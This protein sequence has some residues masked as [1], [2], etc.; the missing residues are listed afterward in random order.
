MK[1]DI[2][3]FTPYENKRKE[4]KDL[5]KY[6]YGITV[7]TIF[8]IGVSFGVNHFRIYRLEKDIEYYTNKMTDSI[9][10][11]ELKEAENINSQINILTEYDKGIEDI[12]KAVRNRDL[13]SDNL[14]NNISSTI[15]SDVSFKSIVIDSGN[16][17]LQ[18][19]SANRSAVAELK[20][21]LS[22]LEE[23]DSVYVN[24][25]S[26]SGAVEGEYSFNIK[27]V[28]KDVD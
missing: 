1:S 14:L 11:S 22:N 10:S 16:I 9:L 4:K 7:I 15:P 27:C 12:S 20:H 19:V 13:V 3:F 24:S 28:L 21:N 2:N 25:I 26:N 18:G 6:I 5:Q 17:L 23:L 8:A